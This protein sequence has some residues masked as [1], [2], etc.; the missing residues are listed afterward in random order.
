[1]LYVMTERWPAARKYRDVFERIK[2]N[3]G[4]AIAQRDTTKPGETTLTT[5]GSDL[6]DRCH[7]LGRGFAGGGREDFNRM[8]SDMTGE[9]L[10][11]D[12]AREHLNAPVEVNAVAGIYEQ[13]NTQEQRASGVQ[14][15]TSGLTFPAQHGS[16]LSYTTGLDF[17]DGMNSDWNMDMLEPNVGI[18]GEFGVWGA[19]GKL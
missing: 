14:S 19:V 7:D 1:M 13:G 11:W 6:R 10:K 17:Y 16:D 18:D 8:I 15:S 9:A 12:H 5:L 2:N 4:D 3:F